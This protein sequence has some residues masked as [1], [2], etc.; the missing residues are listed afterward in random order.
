[1]LAKANASGK[2]FS[3]KI[4]YLYE[5]RLVDRGSDEKK[6]IVIT[7]SD[8]IRV[9]YGFDDKKSRELMKADFI[10]QAKQH[11]D[12]GKDKKNGYVGEHILS[13]TQDDRKQL[14][15]EKLKA[16]TDEYIKMA[17]INK[18]QFV[19]I[20]HNDTD[21]LHVHILFNRAMD[22][23]TKYKSWKEQNKTIERG[24]ALA[25]QNG[26][27]LVKNQK[28][29][30]NCKEVVQLRSEMQDIKDL[31]NSNEI[32]GKARNMLHLEKICETKSIPFSKDDIGR[33]ITIN[34]KTYQEP[35][36]KAVFLLNRT[37]SAKESKVQGEVI[38]EQENTKTKTDKTHE[39]S[40]M[41]GV[42]VP[43]KSNDLKL[44]RQINTP[45]DDYSKRPKKKKRESGHKIKIAK[46]EKKTETSKGMSL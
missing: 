17:G 19:A 22:D 28:E 45:D 24:I 46:I 6:A 12:Y 35:D 5:G 10:D 44:K 4:D 31:R 39:V 40:E 26:F 8:N 43:T 16:I 30:A 21:N 36:L 32:L 3:G 20:S 27:A 15:P 34:N 14:N 41:S 38:N 18:T 2:G 33:T 7:H 23:G 11:K 29:I 42:E 13:F 1:M 9:P 37:E 25:L